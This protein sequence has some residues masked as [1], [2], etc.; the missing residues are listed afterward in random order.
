MYKETPIQS[1]LF[2]LILITRGKGRNREGILPRN[3]GGGPDVWGILPILA[4]I[5]NPDPWT[6]PFYR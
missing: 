3:A 4:G 1:I 2:R 6:L 5:F